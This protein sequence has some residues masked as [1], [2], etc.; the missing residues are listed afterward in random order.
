MRNRKT[1]IVPA[2][3]VVG[4]LLILTRGCAAPRKIREVERGCAA[5]R[6]IWE[7]EE[8]PKEAPRPIWEVE[9][10]KKAAPRPIWDPNDVNSEG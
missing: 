1:F 5:P 4:T 3:F 6:K 2:G 10:E 7:V 8:E 9:D